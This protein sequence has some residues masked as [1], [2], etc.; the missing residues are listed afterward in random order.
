MQPPHS[1]RRAK[2]TERLAET[3]LDALW[4]TG[5]V[6]IRYLT[7]FTGSYA[8][9]V[10]TRAGSL[11]VTD[12]RYQEQVQSEVEGCEVRI[13]KNQTWPEIFAEEI[14][15]R[16]WKTI[17]YEARHLTCESFHKQRT[18]LDEG[19]KWRA[20]PGWVEDLRVVKDKIE[21]EALQR[22]SDV[23]DRVF[24]SLLPEFREGVTEKD[25]LRRMMNRFWEFGAKGP[26]FDP[27]ILFGA[28][29]SLP[30]GQP[31]DT[32]L[33]KGDWVL[34]DFGAVV[35]GYCSDCT[36]TFVF[37]EPDS[38]QRA[39][40]ELVMEAHRAGAS[41]ARVGVPCNE[42]D[43]AARKVLEEGGMGDAFIHGLGH[44]V[45]LEIHE[46]PRVAQPSKEVLQAGMVVTIEPGI[47]VPGWGG[48]RIEN[49]VVVTEGAAQPL[50][51][52]EMGLQPL[53]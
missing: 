53:A 2:L 37:G 6:N 38:L 36:R 1:N 30:H 23:V 10:I 22:S 27:I 34:L 18:L 19:I 5:L 8:Q 11:F 52:S 47:Y 4:V 13:F 40:H 48:I 42:V 21:I 25:I 45:G 33:C 44:G 20:V 50:T 32:A 39:R 49:A 35:E 12:G 43:S 28:R 26:S 51:R 46:A 29:S 14:R 3:E 24:E 31:G 15:A 7:G 9:L 16:G 17:G 41:A